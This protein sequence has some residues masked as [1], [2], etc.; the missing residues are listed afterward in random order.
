MRESLLLCNLD[1]RKEN[2]VKH[3]QSGAY[4]ENGVDL[5][6]LALAYLNEYVE[7]KACGNTVGYAV[8]KSHKDTCEER[9]Y[10]LVKVAPI[11]ILEGGHHHD[12]DRR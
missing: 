3:E 6:Y 11:N 1:Y 9:G 7:D 4:P 10:S 5:L 8:A 12:H 2:E